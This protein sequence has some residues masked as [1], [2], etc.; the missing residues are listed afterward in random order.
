MFIVC[1]IAFYN[2]HYYMALLARDSIKLSF[3]KLF[4][5]DPL[6]Q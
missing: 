2:S 6:A 3:Y 1:P 4:L 5:G